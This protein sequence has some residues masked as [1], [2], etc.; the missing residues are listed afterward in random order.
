MIRRLG[1]L[2][3]LLPAI[4]L[5]GW[6]SPDDFIDVDNDW[7]DEPLTYDNNVL[8]LSFSGIKSYNHWLELHLPAGMWCNKIQ[9]HCQESGGAVISG[10]TISVRYDGAWHQIYSGVMNANAWVEKTIPAGIKEVTKAR[11]SWQGDGSQNRL[12]I[13]E[14]EFWESP[15]P[16]A[17]YNLK[18]RLHG[19]KRG[20][21]LHDD[22]GRLWKTPFSAHSIGGGGKSG[23]SGKSAPSGY[24]NTSI[25]MAILLF[26]TAIGTWI[27]KKRRKHE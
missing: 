22:R 24:A 20:N 3:V 13:N 4:C 2:L 25:L 27:Y 15:A 1:F 19:G 26:F 11:M 12:N 6:V 18:Y 23:K 16:E 10:I 14:F 8:T 17:E 9:I 5:G 7:T 21:L